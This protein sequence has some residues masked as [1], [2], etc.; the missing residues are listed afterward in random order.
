MTISDFENPDDSRYVRWKFAGKTIEKDY[1]GITYAIPLASGTGVVVVEPYAGHPDNAIIFD[2]DGTERI[3][4]VN[5]LTSIG[6]ICFIY[7]YYVG[8]DL[9]LVVALRDLQYGCVFDA[10][11]RCLRTY[12]A[13]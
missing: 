1:P 2:A 3:R 12:E 7:P 5:P 4:L 6:A 10:D 13:R 9:T 11:G 8:P